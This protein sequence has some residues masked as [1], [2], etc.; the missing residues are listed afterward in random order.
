MVPMTDMLVWGP[1]GLPPAVQSITVGRV[2]AMLD[3]ADV[4]WVRL[5]G[6][7]IV[8]RLY[9]AVR[10]QNWDTVTPTV[11]EREVIS[12][13][14]RVEIRLRVRHVGTVCF[15][16]EGEISLTKSG[17]ITFGIQ[18]R[19]LNRQRYNRIG[20]VIHH[21][22]E[23]MRGCSYSL[24]GPAGPAQGLL[25]DM[26]GP[27]IIVGGRPTPIIPTFERLVLDDGQVTSRYTFEGDLFEMEDQRNWTDGS[28]KTYSTPLSS[29][30]PFTAQRGDVVQQRARVA[31]SRRTGSSPQPRLTWEGDQKPG[32]TRPGRRDQ[33]RPS[34]RWPTN[35]VEFPSASRSEGATVR[36]V[37]TAGHRVPTIGFDHPPDA[38]A[39]EPEQ[40]DLFRTL[41]AGHLR[42]EL[43]S[44]TTAAYLADAEALASD[45]DWQIELAVT[46]GIDHL[47]EL[48]VRSL[49]D[50]VVRLVVTRCAGGSADARY[51]RRVRARLGLGASTPLVAG[52]N[53]H[54]VDLNRDRPDVNGCDGVAYPIC[55]QVHSSDISSM[56][57]GVVTQ[58]DTVET[59]RELF[60]LPVHVGPITLA[61]RFNPNATETIALR[62]TWPPPSVDVRQ[63]T[64]FAAAWSVASAAALTAAGASSVTYYR[65]TGWRGVM[66]D[67][68]GP[69]P[70]HP[71]RAD[72]VFPVFHV[73]ADIAGMSG[74]M[75][76]RVDVSDPMRVAAVGAIGGGG[77]VTVLLAN[78]TGQPIDL[79]LEGFSAARSIR[80]LDS[81]SAA[82]ALDRRVAIDWRASGELLTGPSLTLA[83]FET[84]LIR[85]C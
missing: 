42:I 13:S 40:I 77:R 30:W 1:E 78:L 48:D 56:V 47:A 79:T 19:H 10:D 72:M 37:L 80:R 21:P 34:R 76:A 53:A 18:G 59:A 49:K 29:A 69:Q 65:L 68:S 5:D 44:R 28:F 67:P 36:L 74:S 31:T 61:P 82:E 22:P 20:I 85:E 2:A 38:T 4:R 7:E 8:R 25:P 39:P 12:S 15:E 50:R 6:V 83:P 24:I 71:P 33:V 55:P 26:I 46:G 35:S 14:D 64:L 45:L 58:Y 60:G 3:A 57:E 27:Q 62:D 17:V 51:A 32:G 11:L 73:L 63:P 66:G 16:W 43:D 23:R 75:S 81:T 9:V 54:F 84:D 41:S 52:T 70:D